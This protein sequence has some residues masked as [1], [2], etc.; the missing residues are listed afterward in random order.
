VLDVTG[1]I[2]GVGS[3]GVRRYTVLV[4]GG[5]TP[6]KNRLFDLKECLPSSLGSCASRPW[7]FP[8]ESDAARVVRAQ[9]M[10][11]ASP[12]AGLDVVKVGTTQV[13]LREMIPE[14]NRSSLDRFNKKPAKLRLA[15]E[16]AGLLT[17]LSH[18]R[19]AEAFSQE[20][21]IHEL[22]RWATG[23]ALDSVLA[24]GVRFAD[25]SRADHRQFRAEL[26]SPASLPAAMRRR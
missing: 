14:E 1:R 16:E 8:D 21:G 18:L 2:A 7:P 26:R 4:S 25:H 10:L 3:L 5:G 9:R 23:P 19:G 6:E 17:A 11:Q 22:A 13:R 15:V 24:A 20:G 12:T